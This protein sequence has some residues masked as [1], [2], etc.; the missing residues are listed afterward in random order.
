MTPRTIT[1]QEVRA[2]YSRVAPGIQDIFSGEE[3]YEK[4]RIL[5]E[6]LKLPASVQA[7]L[8]KEVGYAILGL[9]KPAET[10]TVFAMHGASQDVAQS[11]VKR[12]A[13]DIL[14][15]VEKIR[16]ETFS[17]L[18]PEKSTAPV[19]P[20]REEGK[21]ATL[22]PKSLPAPAQGPLLTPAVKSA[23]VSTNLIRPTPVPPLPVQPARPRTMASDV[24]AIDPA[25]MA[26]R[27][28]VEKSSPPAV[29]PVPKAPP[30]K[31]ISAPVPNTST[32]EAD[33]KKYGVDPYREP[34]E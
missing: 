24:E 22:P 7:V 18:A 25:S 32:I 27:P 28:A 26:P 5:A 8:G 14:L 12:V 9:R 2:Q 15:E 17:T 31:P 10:L 29:P 19:E 23:P 4:I 20:V 33:M 16:K 1:G 30:L 13:N 6:E 34:V 21:T 3:T 11:I